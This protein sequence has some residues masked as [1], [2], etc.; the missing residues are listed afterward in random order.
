M[1]F[2]PFTAEELAIFG[3]VEAKLLKQTP[4]P[5]HAMSPPNRILSLTHWEILLPLLESLTPTQHEEFRTSQV[6]TGVDGHPVDPNSM[7]TTTVEADAPEQLPPVIDSHMHLDLMF[8]DH[9]ICS[10]DTESLDLME[11]FLKREDLHME[12]VVANYCFPIHWSSSDHH[13]ANDHS[14]RVCPTYGIHPKVASDNMSDARY[15]ELAGRVSNPRCV[16]EVGL[17]FYH[18]DS[19]RAIALQKRLLGRIFDLA[20]ARQQ[21]LVIHCRERREDEYDAA[22]QVMQL[23]FEKKMLDHPI[24]RHCFIGTIPQLDEWAHLLPNC[25][26]GITAKSLHKPTQRDVIKRIPPHR[27]LLDSPH[28]IHQDAPNQQTNSPW[29]LLYLMKDF[30]HYLVL[31]QENLLGSHCHCLSTNAGTQLSFDNDCYILD[32]LCFTKF[33]K[34]TPKKFF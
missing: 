28:L 8:R 22:Y 5:A 16:G 6:P 19:S 21:P 4:K 27:L 10:R 20:K 12:K 31:Y 15:H 18:N 9:R 34:E 2:P 1:P 30:S 29:Q 23:F 7:D 3:Y 11:L 17:D 25:L 33:S 32:R 13:L 24:H 14:R 26:F